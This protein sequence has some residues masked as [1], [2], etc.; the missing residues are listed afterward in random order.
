MVALTTLTALKAEL[1]I[2]V[3][4]YDTRLT[5]LILQ[6]SA[7]I[8]TFLDRQLSRRTLTEI[9]STPWV[10]TRWRLERHLWLAAWPVASIT[11]VTDGDSVLTTDDYVLDAAEGILTRGAVG[12]C[13]M[14]APIVTVVYAG[15]YILPG[16]VGADL[17]ADIERACLDLATRYHH[18]GGR[19]PTLRSETVPGVIEQSWTAVDSVPTVGGLP[20]DVARS[21][22]SYRRAHI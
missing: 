22:S 11:S 3:S 10:E 13:G 7:Q 17:P 18:G 12:Y 1:G 8:E 20:Q 16:S 9:F 15:G 5:S 4:T 6:V 2:T 19:D 21:L 14:W